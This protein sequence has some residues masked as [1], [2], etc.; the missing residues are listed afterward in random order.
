MVIK[1]DIS[2]ICSIMQDF[3]YNLSITLEKPSSPFDW[4]FRNFFLIK[5]QLRFSRS[6]IWQNYRNHFKEGHDFLSR[7]IYIILNILL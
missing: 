6:H 3:L 4:L 2:I 1:Y 5:E 7:K